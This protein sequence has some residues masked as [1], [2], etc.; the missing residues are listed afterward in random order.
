M[1]TSPNI[2][3][4]NIAAELPNCDTVMGIAGAFAIISVPSTYAM[5]FIRLRA[6]YNNN[7]IITIIFGFLLFSEFVLSFLGPVFA[8][9]MHIGPTQ[10]CIN[11]SDPQWV[12][13]PILMSPIFDTLV[14][15]AISIRIV[16]NSFTANTYQS[17]MKSFFCGDGLPN[18]SRNLLK[19]GQLYYLS[20]I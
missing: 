9:S 14:F 13:V 1:Q 17:R 12:S 10:R 11:A 4:G 6:V 2:N 18:M 15:F 16:S 20:V 7:K 3:V 8:R 5:F 19:G